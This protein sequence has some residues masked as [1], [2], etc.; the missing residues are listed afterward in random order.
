LGSKLDV[1][2]I[3]GVRIYGSSIFYMSVLAGGE[4]INIAA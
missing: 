3:L 2:T 1:P 4:R